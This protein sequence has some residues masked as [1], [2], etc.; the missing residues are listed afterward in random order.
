MFIDK[1]HMKGEL[2]H[3]CMNNDVMTKFDVSFYFITKTISK[4]FCRIT[5]FK[6]FDLFCIFK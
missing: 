2:A 5:N 4:N 1:H 6:D 3:E